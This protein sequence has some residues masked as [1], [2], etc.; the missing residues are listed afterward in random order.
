[1][2]DILNSASFGTLA[3]CKDNTPYALALNFAYLDDCF[4]FHGSKKGKKQEFIQNGSKGS[5]SVVLEGSLIPSYFST[6]SGLACP[7]THFFSSVVASGTIEIVSDYKEKV[8]ALDALMQK[9]QSEGRYKELT[10][11]DYKKAIDA[12]NIF[13]LTVAKITKKE[14]YGQKFPKE[15]IKKL[16]K[17]LQKRGTTRD[18]FTINKIKE[19]RDD[20]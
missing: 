9:L 1:M 7:A 15:R 17:N 5:F 11:Q 14:K 2:Q 13:K 8:K 4:Y 20:I 16:V 6:S 12:T 19:L 18:I 3:L 10:N